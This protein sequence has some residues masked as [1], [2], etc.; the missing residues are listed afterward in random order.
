MLQVRVGLRSLARAGLF[1]SYGRLTRDAQMNTIRHLVFDRSLRAG[2][3]ILVGVAKWQC[4][5]KR[6][7]LG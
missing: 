7:V 3:H 6:F 4:R 5:I 1:I 2:T